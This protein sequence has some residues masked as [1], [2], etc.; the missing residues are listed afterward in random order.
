MYRDVIDLREFYRSP[1]GQLARRLVMRRIREFWPD[2]KGQSVLGIGYATPINRVA[3]LMNN[4]AATGGGAANPYMPA[5]LN[6]GN[7][8]TLT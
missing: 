4:G 6:S 7:P 8:Y 1:L 3:A 2:L 5:A